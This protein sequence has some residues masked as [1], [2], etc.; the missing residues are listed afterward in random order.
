MRRRTLLGGLI[1]GLA[2]ATGARPTRARPSNPIATKKKTAA[3]AAW[4]SVFVK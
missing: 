2:A 4:R 3:F 1:G